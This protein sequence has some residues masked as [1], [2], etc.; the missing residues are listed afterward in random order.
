MLKQQIEQDLKTAMLGGDKLR[1]STLRVV[2]SVILYAEVANGS[3]DTGLT[4]PEIIE[5][6]LK[7]AKKRQETAALY[8]GAGEASRAGAELAEK[9]IIDSYLPK[10]LSDEAL[11]QIISEIIATSGATSIQQMG[12]VISKV[13]DRVGASADGSRIARMAKE[14]LVE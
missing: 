11:R 7:E 2:K 13:K 1:V 14:G 6:L 9:A 4:D 8:D 12:Q 10:Q 5:L 3:R